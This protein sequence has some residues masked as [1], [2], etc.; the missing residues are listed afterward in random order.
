M[1][2][3]ATLAWLSSVQVDLTMRRTPLYINRP[4]ALALL[5]QRLRNV[6]CWLLISRDLLDVGRPS[7]SHP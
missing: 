3:W 2:E 5:A 7:G 6:P 4:P 1:L